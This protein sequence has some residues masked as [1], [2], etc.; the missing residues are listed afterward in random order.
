[1]VLS[2]T[3][4]S[5][6]YQRLCRLLA[7]G[8]AVKT[9]KWQGR[10]RPPDMVELLNQTF[11]APIPPTPYEG[12][13]SLP[14]NLP[15]AEDHFEER[16]GGKPLNP[17]EQWKNWPY[18]RNNIANDQFRTEGRRFTHTYMERFWPKLAGDG[19]GPNQGI[20]YPYGDLDDLISLFRREPLTR[21]AYLPVW[22]P[23]DTGV[24]HGGR[25]PCT[26]GYHF[27]IRGN[28][29]RMHCF[30]P[31]RSCDAIRHLPDDIYLACRLTQWICEGLAPTH[32]VTPGGLTMFIVSLHA[33]EQERNVLRK[34]GANTP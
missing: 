19:D 3:P 17:G 26:L 8:S 2:R 34:I 9:E 13:G 11:E 32:A 6:E 12:F 20:R 29:M 24:V 10:D 4:I 25:V 1:M 31:I 30:Y 33:W 27:I 28:P 16:V 22:F 5:D 15:W 21:Q 18:Y 7:N 14:V 23:E